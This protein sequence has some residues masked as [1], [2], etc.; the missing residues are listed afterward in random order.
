MERV[1][2]VTGGSRGAGRGIA[3]GLAEEG[4][5]VA[6]TYRRGADDADETVEAIQAL[7]RRAVAI[8]SDVSIPEDNERAVAT[9]IGELGG[10][11][12]LVLNAGI[13]SRGQTVADTDPAELQ[14]VMSVHALGPHHLCSVAVPHMR[15]NERGDIVFISSVATLSHNANGAPYN[16]G[17]AAMESL[18]MTLAKEERGNGIRVNVVAPGL[19]DTDMGRR[20][21]KGA[22]NID[23]IGTVH[24]KQPFGRICTPEDIGDAVRFFVSD[25]AFLVTGEKLNVWGG[26]QEWR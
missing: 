21:V 12:A 19:I 26:G 1:A 10:L 7:G 18:A 8:Q 22:A 13:A 5:D 4:F 11:H 2:L 14:R 20:L 15:E 6:L 17:K 24:E 25:K 3:V 16:M 9:T 23:D